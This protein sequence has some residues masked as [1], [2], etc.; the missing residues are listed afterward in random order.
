MIS[1]AKIGLAIGGSGEP[2][3][4]D[5]ACH[6]LTKSAAHLRNDGIG[7]TYTA[8]QVLARCQVF[9]VWCSVD[10]GP[11]DEKTL[12]HYA[13]SYTPYSHRATMA[14]LDSSCQRAAPSCRRP[15]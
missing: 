2:E 4:K 5:S 14:Q 7:M 8:S 11:N 3:P 1:S 12:R 15:F 13:T 6:R 9:W 10:K